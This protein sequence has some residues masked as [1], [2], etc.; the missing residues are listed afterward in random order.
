MHEQSTTIPQHPPAPT[1]AAIYIRVSS[2]AQE[3]HYGPDVQEQTCRDYCAAHGL[4]VVSVWHDTLPGTTVE[5]PGLNALLAAAG[6]GKV[7]ALV[8]YKQDRLGRGDMFSYQKV[9][10]ATVAGLK[11]HC[12]TEP[13]K[14][15]LAGEADHFARNI[16]SGEEARNIRMRTQ[17]GRKARAAAGLL[18]PGAR[19]LYG[20]RW[21]AFGGKE[22]GGYEVEAGTA[23]VVRRIYRELGRGRP[24]RGIADGLTGDG[25]PPPNGGRLW[26]PSTVRDLAKNPRYMGQ[27]EGY[28]RRV[29]RDPDTGKMRRLAE[30][31]SGVPLGEGAIPA[32]V[33]AD[34]WHAAQACLLANKGATPRNNRAPEAYLLR[35]GHVVCGQCG[36]TVQTYIKHLKG[37]DVPRY[38]VLRD[39]ERHVGCKNVQVDAATLDG[40]AWALVTRIMAEPQRL[41]D[42]LAQG[43]GDDP[44]EAELALMERA[45]AGAERRAANLTASIAR[46]DDDATRAWLV[47]GLK[48][49]AGERGALERRRAELGAR[50]AEA[51]GRRAN[52][53]SLAAWLERTRAA[54]GRRPWPA[55]VAYGSRVE[56]HLAEAD[57]PFDRVAATLDRMLDSWEDDRPPSPAGW[58]LDPG[59][60]ATLGLAREARAP[61]YEERRAAVRALGLVA[62]LHG[63]GAAE[64]FTFTTTHD[65]GTVEDASTGGSAGSPRR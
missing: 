1:P 58:A 12:P 10:C 45:L 44:D 22:K 50:L 61:S 29:E 24:T 40:A 9:R 23:A 19:P 49:V 16:V 62:T 25:V 37:R 36:A 55:A 32:L 63:P 54:L 51:A 42:R 4:D 7:R 48:E 41:L 34:E 65:V 5:R 14:D 18:V 15:G 60:A 46:E 57:A 43:D 13:L 11:L 30:E 64:P 27:G 59:A 8:F 56:V 33:T 3:T 6:A 2:A 31:L 26:R 20:Y 52:V 21:C 39:R 47:V 53:V 17:S 38:R 35:A 28:R